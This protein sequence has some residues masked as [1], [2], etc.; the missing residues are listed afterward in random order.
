LPSPYRE[1]YEEE[2]TAELEAMGDNAGI[3]ALIFAVVSGFK[4]KEMA[5]IAN[6]V[7]TDTTH[8]STQNDRLWLPRDA[9]NR[10][11]GLSA[12]VADEDPTPSSLGGSCHDPTLPLCPCNA[13]RASPASIIEE[14]HSPKVPV[15]GCFLRNAPGSVGLP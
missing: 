14:T 13:E 12:P 4:V 3:G 6:Q 2:W 15:S 10:V 11:V 5:T 8:E 9:E 1:R 7:A